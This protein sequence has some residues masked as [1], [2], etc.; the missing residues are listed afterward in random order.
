MAE[1]RIETD[2]MGQVEVQNDRYWGAQTQRSLQNFEIGE[3]LF[4]RPFIRAYGILKH[5][6]AWANGELGA[7]NPEK[8]ELICKA[9]QEV[10]EGKLDEHF[11]L[12]V[13]QTGSG[14][15]FNMNCNEV[16]SNRAIEMANGKLGSKSPVHPNDDCNKGQSSNDT[17]PTAM[18]IAAV[19]ELSESLIPSVG[20]LRDALNSKAVKY[21][22]VVKT[23]R[24]HLQDAVPLT[25]GQEI[26]GWVSQ[27]DH[28][29]ERLQ[30]SL[31]HLKEVPI[32]GTAVGTGLNAH[33][34]FSQKVVQKINELSG[35]TF[36]PS[37]VKFES[38]AA[39]DA[40][41]FASSAMRTLAGVLMKIGNDIRW[42]ASG[43]RCGIGELLIPENEPGSSIM[44]GKVN[45]T[46]VEA[47]TMVVTQVYGNDAAVAFAAS[48]GSFELNTYKPVM[49]H[50]LL[51]SA[52][53]LSDACDS[54]RKNCVIGIEPNLPKIKEY[55]DNSLMLVTA[56]NPHIGY[57]KAAQIAKKAYKENSTLK[58]A[59]IALGFLTADQFDE[60]VNPA[61][62]TGIK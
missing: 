41:A 21:N 51:E 42:L 61:N 50:N 3:I 60:W 62:M 19:C 37:P 6:C 33:P 48:Q 7:M 30:Y 22:K 13:F 47:L 12:V 58:Q 45:P 28:S 38:I 8:S 27:L 59:A 44:P 26:S 32:G 15:Q 23:G 46:Q 2:S 57:D 40:I 1:V 35:H 53:I 10:I 39:H 20:E 54:F 9:A 17:F 36:V 25:L 31:N 29:L 43:P 52:R 5:S 55:L 24:T 49:I 4:T 16:I 14:T 34:E 11:P 56:L 18:R